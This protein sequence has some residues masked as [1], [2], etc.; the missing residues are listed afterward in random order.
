MSEKQELEPS[1]EYFRTLLKKKVRTLLPDTQ[2]TA[3]DFQ[4]FSSLR[5]IPRFE[6]ITAD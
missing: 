4:L 2:P 6:Y 5:N 1:T 3:Q